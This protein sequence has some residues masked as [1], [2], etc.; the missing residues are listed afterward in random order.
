MRKHIR[1]NLGIFVLGL[2]VTL[3]PLS[4]LW[5]TNVS[6]KAMAALDEYIQVAEL[7]VQSSNGM[8]ESI[9][10]TSETHAV[11]I[12]PQSSSTNVVSET[13]NTSDI[14]VIVSSDD[15]TDDAKENSRPS[16]GNIIIETAKADKDDSRKLS[17][18]GLSF[19]ISEDIEA[20][21]GELQYWSLAKVAS[22]ECGSAS[23]EVQL[24]VISTIFNRVKCHAFP[25]N[26]YDVVM[27]EGQFVDNGHPF[28]RDENGEYREIEEKDVPD[29]IKDGI[30]IVRTQGD[31]SNGALFFISTD[32]LSEEMVNYFHE[33]YGEPCLIVDGGKGEFFT[34]DYGEG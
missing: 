12:T 25:D 1:D 26:F 18:D 19:D 32:L 24:A 28:F 11:A 16:E 22:G 30:H 4:H 7:D 34:K 15:Q 9:D 14:N 13:D 27:Q 10:E 6:R 31:F 17:N 29:S 33:L 21:G 23:Q 3:L 8:L 20:L 2:I 5:N